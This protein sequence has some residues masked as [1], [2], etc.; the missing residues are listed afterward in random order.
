MESGCHVEVFHTTSWNTKVS[1]S[2]MLTFSLSWLLL[3][4]SS[5]TNVLGKRAGQASEP[6]KTRA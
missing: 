3:L 2:Q 4:S 1:G 5:F 6:V